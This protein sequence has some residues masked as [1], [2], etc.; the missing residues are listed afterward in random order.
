MRAK[1]GNP[2]VTKNSVTNLTATP[3]NFFCNKDS[4]I[5]TMPNYNKLRMLTPVSL[6]L[7]SLHKRYQLFLKSSSIKSEDFLLPSILRMYCVE[8]P[9]F[10]FRGVLRS[11]KNI[12]QRFLLSSIF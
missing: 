8:L 1:V 6:C 4:F 12:S 3:F 2:T 5:P 10:L 9:D 11:I 7:G